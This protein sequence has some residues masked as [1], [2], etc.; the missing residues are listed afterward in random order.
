MSIY[1]ELSAH[2]KDGGDL[3]P[4]HR[5]THDGQTLAGTLTGEPR[6]QPMKNFD[7]EMVDEFLVDLDTADGPVTVICHAN[8]RRWFLNVGRPEPGTHLTIT[9]TGTE[10]RAYTFDVQVN[11]T[12]AAKT[13]GPPPSTPPDF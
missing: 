4:F 11:G 12:E 13:D 6:I 8:L 9:R 10:N 7:G 5:W 2:F 1:D 3:P